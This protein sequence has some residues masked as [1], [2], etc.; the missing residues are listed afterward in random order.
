MDSHP[1]EEQI[2]L[3]DPK[4]SDFSSHREEGSTRQKHQEKHVRKQKART[5]AKKAK[6]VEGTKPRAEEG[7]NVRGGDHALSRAPRKVQEEEVMRRKATHS[8]KHPKTEKITLGSP[9][10][11]GCSRPTGVAAGSFSS[12]GPVCRALARPPTALPGRQPHLRCHSLSG[13]SSRSGRG[14]GLGSWNQ[15]ILPST[16][17]HSDTRVSGNVKFWILRT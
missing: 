1:S 14:K 16:L 10:L 3:A 4:F 12:G 11:L 7:T 6:R 15:G 5:G 13:S 17:I 8:S 2:L 9:G